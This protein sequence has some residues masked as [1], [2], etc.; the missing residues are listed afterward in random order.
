MP[1][2]FLK[3]G[4]II[5]WHLAASAGRFCGKSASFYFKPQTAKHLITPE[6]KMLEIE[7]VYCAV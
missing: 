6:V 5:I 4:K 2:S 1:E 3:Q 7:L